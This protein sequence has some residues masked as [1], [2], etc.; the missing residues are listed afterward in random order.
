MYSSVGHGGA[1]GYLAVMSI[2]SMN[3]EIMRSSALV[4]NLIVSGIAFYGFR[5]AGY[6]SSKIFLPLAA[7]SIPFAF[8]GAGYPAD[9][10]LYKILLGII[11]LFA[12]LKISGALDKVKLNFKVEFSIV[13]AMVTG[14]L[15]GFISGMIGIGGGI[16]L[17]PLILLFGWSEIKE[18]AGISALFI[19]VNSASGLLRLSL[20]GLNVSSEMTY[21]TIAVFTGGFIG[22]HW[23]SMF[24]NNKALRI[25]LSFVLFFASMKLIFI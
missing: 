13:K 9:T 1:S 12:S 7:T 4:L 11:L 5:K 2:L 3:P 24:A 15:L 21:M 16:I 25:L 23:G 14:A 19:F 18:T 10:D 20:D 8:I 22:S 6:F 17:S